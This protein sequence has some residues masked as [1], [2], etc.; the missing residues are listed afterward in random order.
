[1]GS[2][3]GCHILR[4]MKGSEGLHLYKKDSGAFVS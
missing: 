4:I 3:Q 1:M 2:V